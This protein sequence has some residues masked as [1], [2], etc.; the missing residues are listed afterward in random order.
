MV[1]LG[2]GVLVMRIGVGGCR[3]RLALL[4]RILGLVVIEGIGEEV[5]TEMPLTVGIEQVEQ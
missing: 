2:G 3:G 1:G 4:V 5:E